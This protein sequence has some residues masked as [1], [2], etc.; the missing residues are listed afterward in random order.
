VQELNLGAEIDLGLR[1]GLAGL[2][3]FPGRL[4]IIK[5]NSTRCDGFINAPDV[6]KI[7]IP[8]VDNF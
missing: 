4:Q 8:W 6:Q 5:P 1:K 2:T 7:S 3:C